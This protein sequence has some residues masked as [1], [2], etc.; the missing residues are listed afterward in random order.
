[1]PGLMPARNPLRRVASN[2]AWSHVWLLVPVVA[3][4]PAQAL[5]DSAYFESTAYV[6]FQTCRL[7]SSGGQAW[8]YSS[9]PAGSKV[10]SVKFNAR[11]ACQTGCGVAECDI[12]SHGV[13]G[14]KSHW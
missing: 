7:T 9:I 12:D 11:S 2:L 14:R 5:A 10:T 6:D 4:A 3:V 1:M 13:S 8:A